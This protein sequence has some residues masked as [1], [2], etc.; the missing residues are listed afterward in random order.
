LCILSIK[1]PFQIDQKSNLIFSLRYISS[2]II[3]ILSIQK[4]SCNLFF[5]IQYPKF[6][7]NGKI[8]ISKNQDVTSFNNLQTLKIVLNSS[9]IFAFQELFKILKKFQGINLEYFCSKSFKIL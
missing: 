4:F 2:Q 8:V 1:Y 9:S 3:S 7:K 5:S 6:S